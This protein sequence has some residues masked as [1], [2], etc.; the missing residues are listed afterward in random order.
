MRRRFGFTLVELL[1][2]IAIIAVLVSILMPALARARLQA[3]IVVCASNM[4][5]V[6]IALLGYANDNK[7]NL[8]PN[9]GF[10]LERNGPSIARNYDTETPPTPPV[11]LRGLAKYL[12]N[13]NV[14]MCPG[15]YEKQPYGE[16]GPYWFDWYDKGANYWIDTTKVVDNSQFRIG[17]VYMWSNSQP[18]SYQQW[19][20][21][22]TPP[23]YPASF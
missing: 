4:R 7:G 23:I 10:S 3:Q 15:W 17:Y 14:M 11:D 12:G 1:V 6:G 21:P 18:C 19:Q 2:V 13:T 20:S 9:G 22:T 5:Q 8:P 16:N